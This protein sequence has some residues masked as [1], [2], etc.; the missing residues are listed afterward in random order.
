[1]RR[2]RDVGCGSQIGTKVVC[3]EALIY[4]RSTPNSR[5]ARGA[6]KDLLLSANFRPERV[7]HRACTD[8]ARLPSSAWASS[9]GGMSLHGLLNWQLYKHSKGRPLHEHTEGRPRNDCVGGQDL[10]PVNVL[11]GLYCRN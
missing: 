2:V 9:C 8:L 6:R 1:M 11:N 4:V 10:A 7:Q 5:H 3:P